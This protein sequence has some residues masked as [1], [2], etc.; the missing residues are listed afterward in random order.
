MAI[1]TIKD[2]IRGSAIETDGKSI[3]V[4]NNPIIPFIE[5]DGT[6]PDI[7]KAMIQVVDAAVKTSYNGEKEIFWTEVF[8]GE[9]SFNKTGEWLPEE[10]LDSFKKYK[11]GIKGPLTTPI[12]GGIRS[13]NVTMRQVLNLYACIRPVR[14]FD[15]VPSPMK[16]P[17]LVN[18]IVFRENTE[19]VYAGIEWKSN[20][21]D[22][23]KVIKFLN[24]EMN[25]KITE[26]TGIGIK[27]MSP[28]ASKDITRRAIKYAIDQKKN[29][30]TLVHKGNIMKFTEGAFK[31]WGYEVAKEEFADVMV[32]EA[33]LNDKYNG[34]LPSG[35][36]L[37]NDRIA[38]AM[39]QQALLRPSEYQ[40]IVT[41]N[42]NGDYISDALAAQ[43]GGLGIAPGAN[44]SDTIAIFEA[45]HG[46]A[47]KYANMDKVN[48]GSIILS[49]VM[50]LEHLGWNE[51]AQMIVSGMEKA[52]K[53]KRVT[54]DLAR[55]MEG[56][57]EIKCSEFAREIIDN[58]KR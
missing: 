16:T 15:G 55:M 19:D 44:M 29:V 24:N 56:A 30:V 1:Q 28:K 13:L 51:A 50:M 4:P 49:S 58:F 22:A 5:G 34:K 3:R 23:K 27:I 11:V 17:E 18:M 25:C 31:E 39:F 45:T 42:L 9:K 2:N 47:P 54:Y 8:A 33:E 37:L 41:P 48:P 40:V 32:T 57:T 38:D 43:V 46:T 36:I 53:S 14:Y 10:T 35:K 26:T 12:G 52:I 6:G 20:G 21:E 7:T